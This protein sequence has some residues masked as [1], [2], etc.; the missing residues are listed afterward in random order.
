MINRRRVL[1]I[2]VGIVGG[3]IFSIFAINYL[4]PFQ[5]IDLQSL[6]IQ[7]NDLPSTLFAGN[8]ERQ[9]PDLE[10]HYDMMGKQTIFSAPDEITG[11]VWIYIFHSTY[12]GYRMFNHLSLL[13]V[14]MESQEGVLTFDMPEVGD[15]MFAMPLYK[16]KQGGWV[17][18][19]A[20]QR[21]YSVVHIQFQ[22]NSSQRLHEQDFV[23]Y[24]RKL[25]ERLKT[26]VCD[27]AKNLLGQ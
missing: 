23:T 16:D 1:L 12:D 27:K 24:T 6:L 25:D 7:P 13:D 3:V 11:Q 17:I 2:L 18:N 5:N 22:T 26:T 9:G 21:C 15:T 20:F 4:L 14:Y 8:F 10:W 19:I